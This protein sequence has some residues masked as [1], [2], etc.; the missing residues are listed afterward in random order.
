[1]EGFPRRKAE[2]NQPTPP[3]P[4]RLIGEGRGESGTHFPSTAKEAAGVWQPLKEL[5][6]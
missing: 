6:A 5:P 1:M 2:T 3:P 4:P